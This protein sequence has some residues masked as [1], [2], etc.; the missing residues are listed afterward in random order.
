MAAFKG[1]DLKVTIDLKVIFTKLN[2]RQTDQIF[3]HIILT[4]VYA[5]PRDISLSRPPIII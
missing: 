2:V 5:S 4:S 3:R 1:A